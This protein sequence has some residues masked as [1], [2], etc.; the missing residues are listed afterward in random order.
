MFLMKRH[1]L[2]IISFP[3]LFYCSSAPERVSTMDSAPEYLIEVDREYPVMNFYI[4]E[5]IPLEMTRESAVGKGEKIL[6]YKGHYYILDYL[7]H[8]VKKF[9]AAGQYVSTYDFKGRG[10]HEYLTLSDIQINPWAETLDILDP[11]GKI[12]R[13]RLNGKSSTRFLDDIRFPDMRQVSHF[14]WIDANRMILNSVNLPFLIRFFDME[15]DKVVKTTVKSNLVRVGFTPIFYNSPFLYLEDQIFYVNYFKSD[16]FE[17]E[18]DDL[19]SSFSF[20]FG[21][22]NF[23]FEELGEIDE[24]FDFNQYRRDHHKVFPTYNMFLNQDYI[25][26]G[27]RYQDAIH[28]FVRRASDGQTFRLNFP[29]YVENF[30]DFQAFANGLHKDHFRAFIKNPAEVKNIL[31]GALNKDEFKDLLDRVDPEDNPLIVR[32]RMEE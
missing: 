18:V 15:A 17:V 32:Y 26:I 12:V 11:R 1:L 19:N 31:D 22:N 30:M 4:E 8:D 24:Q 16:V 21:E 25:G 3:V 27:V 28:H 10:A 2:L 13:H 9:D 7:M 23:E 29:A 5:I 14:A 20:Y 6:E